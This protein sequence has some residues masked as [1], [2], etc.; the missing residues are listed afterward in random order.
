MMKNKGLATG[1]AS[2]VF[3]VYSVLMFVAFGGALPG[4]WL[5]YACS[6]LLV[7]L[8]IGVIW[9]GFGE[10][11]SYFMG[12]PL[13]ALTMIFLI[14]QLLISF[15]VCVLPI[16][17]GLVTEVILL[18]IYLI[19]AL[20]ALLGRN[21]VEGRQREIREKMFYI[22]SISGDIE[23]LAARTDDPLARKK[24]NALYET[25]RYSDPM[26]HDSL[27]PLERRIE[28]QAAVLSEQVNS[29]DWENVSSLC[30]TLTHLVEERNRKCKLLK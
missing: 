8:F 10:R 17:T 29:E 26:S 22:Q 28:E 19:C 13:A 7:G 23:A 20:G 18:G 1:V 3:A 12:L 11:K 4:F 6:I 16:L 14:I 5:G 21:A 15:I 27:A 30:D 9:K 25:V 24:I 2:V